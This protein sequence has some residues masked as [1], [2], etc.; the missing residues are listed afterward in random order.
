MKM[1]YFTDQLNKDSG[2]S[3]NNEFESELG[4]GALEEPLGSVLAYIGRSFCCERITLVEKNPEGFY[5]CTAEWYDP[6]KAHS[7]K[8]YL[9]SL[10]SESVKPY[11][12]YLEINHSL[13]IRDIEELSEEDPELYRILIP[14]GVRS[15]VVGQL[16]FDKEDLGFFCV[17]NPSEEKFDELIMVVEAFTYYAAA[18]IHSE[19]TIKRFEDMAYHNSVK[20]SETNVKKAVEASSYS[21]GEVE[22]AYDELIEIHPQN[23][24]YKVLYSSKNDGNAAEGQLCEMLAVQRKYVHPLD[25]ENF[26]E[27]WNIPLMLDRLMRD[28][29]SRGIRE[30]FRMEKNDE[31]W[32]W[33]ELNVILFVHNEHSPIL[34][35]FA[36]KL[37]EGTDT[38]FL[39]EEN[40]PE[41][42]G[43][44]V[45][46]Q[47]TQFFRE[48]DSWVRRE[49]P[50]YILTIA[51]DLNNFRLYNDIFGRNAGDEYLRKLYKSMSEAARAYEGFVGYFGG[52]NFCMV[53]PLYEINEERIKRRVESEVNAVG[54][55]EGFLPCVG[56]YI[57]S[58]A[59]EHQH[60]RYDKATI[61]LAR[62]RGSFTERAALYDENSYQRLR[63]QQ[64]LLMD[65]SRGI[66][67]R[68]FQVYMQPKVELESGRII[69]AEALV[70]W[71]H[72][73]RL[74][75][76]SYFIEA[77]ENNGY[78]VA[79]DRY[80]WE[81]TCKWLSDIA[82]RG[83][84]PLPV[85]VNVSRIDSYF[86][87]ISELFKELVLKYSLKPEWIEVEITESAYSDN[88][89]RTENMLKKLR[90]F[91]IRV[92]MDDFGSGYSSLN[93][94]ESS[95]VDVL[96]LDYRFLRGEASRR[97]LYVIEAVINMAKLLDLELIAEGVEHE[98]HLKRL[99]ELGCRYGQGTL[100]YEPMPLCDYE[101]LLRNTLNRGEDS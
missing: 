55:E 86:M 57:S 68:E 101:I 8:E 62:I 36:R 23:D 1:T 20:G 52:D 61:A 26:D 29:S 58:D 14:Q 16:S 9:Q 49:K 44:F 13:Y 90:D 53:A 2:E 87:D 30:C 89:E 82:S 81:E 38:G 35:C 95:E 67:D 12:K 69:G 88:D 51:C 46:K 72:E 45:L 17:D 43:D 85:S 50:D 56:L 47:D 18:I 70:R 37:S 40:I 66:R 98:E 22:N 39:E 78:I 79:L 74:L 6:D 71:K 34:M 91:G 92:L 93:M 80:V 31:G 41:E 28:K 73:G 3:G 63:F 27:F 24:Y 99:C 100:F 19:K 97:K 96:K 76:P 42:P 64:V 32:G 33:T 75:T 4:N 65:A 94:L 77:M 83:I 7:K 25:L 60:I 11:Y 5:D 10:S 84:E 21:Y 15:S 48:I 54:F 59:S